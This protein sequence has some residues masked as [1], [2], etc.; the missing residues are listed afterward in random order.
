MNSVIE[1]YS[2]DED[3]RGYAPAV[4]TQL[5]ATSITGITDALAY[6]TN[7]YGDVIVFEQGY[8]LVSAQVVMNKSNVSLLSRPGAS[9]PRQTVL[10]GGT[11]GWAVQ[12][13][14]AIFKMTVGYYHME[15]LS[16]SSYCATEPSIL[17]DDASG[18]GDY[19]GFGSFVNCHFPPEAG[20]DATKYGIGIKGAN[21]ITVDGCT[22]NGQKNAGIATIS[23]GVGYSINTTVKNSIFRGCTYGLEIN[24]YVYGWIVDNCLFN[25]P[26]YPAS[27]TMTAPIN[28]NTG[29]NG[30]ITVAN[31]FGSPAA[32]ES[33][34][35][36]CTII[37]GTGGYTQLA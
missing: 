17:C 31:S 13:W 2:G 33:G 18:G 15:G 26:S 34:A 4:F 29:A 3:G 30:E 22:F 35:G 8:Y 14:G 37:G 16:L 25:T 19:G 7:R 11:T 23:G 5:G 10:F 6:C 12:T 28:N 9:G 27:Q 24:T 36:S 1:P 20:V 21:V 32:V